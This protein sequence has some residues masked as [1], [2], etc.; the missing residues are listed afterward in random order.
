MSR[1]ALRVC[2]GVIAAA[3]AIGC[4]EGT[5]PRF[6]EVADVGVF[7]SAGFDVLVGQTL[8]LEG[9]AITWAGTRVDERVNVWASSNTSI[10]TVTNSGLVTG[11]AAGTTTI[12][13]S[14]EGVTSV[15]RLV[16]VVPQTGGVQ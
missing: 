12:T 15:G 13:A 10:A 5:D 2:V 11:I 1:K 16:T 6:D 3:L 8:Q 14:A 9:R 7:S 4:S